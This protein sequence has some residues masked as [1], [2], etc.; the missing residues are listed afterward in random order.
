MIT[1]A[2]LYKMDDKTL[3]EELQKLLKDLANVQLQVR[4]N[5]DKKSHQVKEHKKQ[6]ARLKT[7]QRE[8][9]EEKGDQEKL[10]A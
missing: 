9:K 10:T 4:T 3:E 2:E 6:I 1:Y 5:S 8:R 7:I